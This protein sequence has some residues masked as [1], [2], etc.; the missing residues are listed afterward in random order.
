MTALTEVPPPPAG[1]PTA[2]TRAAAEARP[3]MTRRQQLILVVL[4]GSQFMMSVDFS[5]LNVALPTIGKGL[6]FSLGDLQWIGTAMMLPAAGLTLL[7]GR[8]ADLAGR[9]RLFLAG[10]VL[11]GAGSLAGG[12]ATSPSVLLAARVV[13][14][15]ATALATPAA[16]ALLT[17]SFPEGPL[18]DR[19]LGLNGT[20]L[21]TGFTLGAV[22]GGTLTSL[23]SWRWA[24]FINVPVAVVMV[25]A[26]PRVIAESRGERTRLDLPG[27]AT[28]TG[29]LFALV[30]G[31]SSAGRFGWTAPQTVA[32]LAAAVVL[33]FAFWRI[34]LRAAAP[35]VPMRVL[36]LRTVSWGNVG[37]LITFTMESSVI[38]LA[39]LYLQDVLGYSPIATGFAF[40]AMGVAAFAGG[41][42]APR[43]I[44]RIGSRTA[45][46]LGLLVQ[47]LATVPLLAM[48]AHTSGLVIF[49]AASS[50]GAFGHI[51]AVVS[52]MVT[53]TSGLPDS[54]QGLA[55]GLAS[56]TQ[57]VGI[58][59]GIPVISAIATARIGSAHD[60]LTGIR[61]GLLVDACVVL[62]GAALVFLFLNRTARTSH[63]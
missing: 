1:A 6:G 38:F 30:F 41:L 33:L 53:A 52:Y 43:V 21:S 32:A 36:T 8:I 51:G 50:V 25:L 22:F 59:V 48:D 31:V 17:T 37:G 35:L 29:G 44:G 55:S 12:L 7:F 13:Q 14:G 56:M 34:E 46:W 63:R 47:G 62:L 4:L 39:T 42:A 49:L 28:V 40:A 24:F 16:L 58:T 27:A 3:R 10:M 9:R 57:Q 61:T 20:L 45:L 2:Q 26:V 54:E 60:T 5:I 23:L 15:L 19:A 11:L 18:R